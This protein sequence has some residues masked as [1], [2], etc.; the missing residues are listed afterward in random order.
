MNEEVRTSL[1]FIGGM[2]GLL[3]A[4]G[5]FFYLKPP[6]HINWFYG[7]RTNR[8]RKSVANWHYANKLAAKLLLLFIQLAALLALATL[9]WLHDSISPDALFLI[10]VFWFAIFPILVVPIVEFKLSRFEEK[11]HSDSP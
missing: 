7:Y 6:R 11:Q 8:A 5:I 2:Y 10:I 4:F 3:L 9:Y 1:Y